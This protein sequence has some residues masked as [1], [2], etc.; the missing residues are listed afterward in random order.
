MKTEIHHDA[1]FVVTD[2]TTVV[3]MTTYSATSYDKI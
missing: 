1:N 2:G 3:I